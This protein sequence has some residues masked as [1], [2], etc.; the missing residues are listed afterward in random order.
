MEITPFEDLR[1]TTITMIVTLDSKIH[2]EIA[3][4]LLPITRIENYKMKNTVK[5][6]LPHSKNPGDIVSMRYKRNTR[7]IIKNNKK[8]FKNA[9]T[10]DI[11]TKIKNISL[12]LSK[13]S[14]QICG[15]SSKEDGVEA[16][17]HVINH[18]Q[19]VQEMLNKMNDNM[20]ESLEL[21]KWIKN[22]TKGESVE[23]TIIETKTCNKMVLNIH[24][25]IMDNYICKPL[26]IPE[27][28][29]KT[30]AKYLLS[31]SVDFLY[32]SDYCKKL[33]YIL[34]LKNVIK[35]KTINIEHIELAMVNYNFSLN[36]QVDRAKLDQLINEQYG[37]IS[38]YNNALSPSVTI[39]LRYKPTLNS[40]VKRRKNKVPHHTFL[41]YRSGSVTQSGPGEELM[42]KAYYKFMNFISEIK[43]EIEYK[44]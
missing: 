26:N 23:K 38:R 43:P 7:G 33:D 31:L 28:F 44:P 19:F 13:N 17:N 2:K 21:I 35:N 24:N 22:H 11:S 30:L 25:I 42:K 27:Y 6:K 4:H 10:I 15:A 37:F 3:Y 20:N 40:A 8:P 9:V 32:H 39:E 34:K 29:D 16:S 14:I 12:K 1:I 36:F 5:C 18:L 41:V